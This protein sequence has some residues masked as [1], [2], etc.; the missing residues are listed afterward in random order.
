MLNTKKLN[1]ELKNKAIMV[2]GGTGSFGKA[3]INK[4]LAKKNYNQIKK[5]V[6]FSRDELKQTDMLNQIEKKK[7][8]K[9]RFFIGDV[10]DRDRLVRAME[11][12][13]IVI[14]AAALK[15]VPIAES[16]PFEFIKTNI[17]GA[18]N[19][20]DAALENKVKNVIALSTDKAV[21]P[22]NLYGATKLASDKLFTSA[23]LIKGSKKIKFSVVRYGN[24]FASR[25]SVIPFFMKLNKEKKMIPVTHKEMTRFNITLDA[26]C[27]FV[28]W[29]LINNLGGEVFVPKLP[30]YKILDL[31]KAINQ[32]CKVHFTGVRAGEKIFEELI[33]RA[34][35]PNTYDLNYCYSLVD[36]VHVDTNNIYNKKKYKKVS[37]YFEYNSSNNPHFLKVDEI[38]KLI[39]SLDKISY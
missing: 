25:G 5:I 24:V 4:L 2:T 13:D 18:Q 6:I 19:V 11:G 28:F 33:S 36:K 15:H 31:V 39:N 38:K 35:S 26:A 20:I 32:N 29:S 3:F 30:S 16:N 37:E 27:D 22:I 34:D 10:R 14:H 7:L 17:L 12:I 9:I 1:S 21:S 8:K 23:N